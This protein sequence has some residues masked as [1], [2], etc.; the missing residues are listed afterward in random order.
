MPFQNIPFYHR[1]SPH[2]THPR[3]RR[4]RCRGLG[5]DSINITSF[6]TPLSFVIVAARV[7]RRQDRFRIRVSPLFSHHHLG[8]T[9]IIPLIWPRQG[10]QPKPTFLPPPPLCICVPST[11]RDHLA[12]NRVA[13]LLFVSLV[14][15]FLLLLVHDT[16][17]SS[18]HA[19]YGFLLRILGCSGS[20]SLP[21]LAREEGERSTAHAIP[22][23]GIS[24][25]R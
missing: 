13:V 9:Y 22:H 7:C 4:A 20:V 1:L 18:F 25:V 17:P 19:H 16:L 14:L 23:D 2:L 24:Y 8:L 11:L 6:Q 5:D 10:R 15:H 3:R 12:A 21:F